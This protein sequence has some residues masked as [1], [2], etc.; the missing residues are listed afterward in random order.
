MN[1][2]KEMRQMRD[3]EFMSTFR[4]TLRLFI[5]RNSKNPRK[6]ALEF[7][8]NNSHPRYYVSRSR[9]YTV[10]CS[11]IRHGK[12]PVRQDLQAQMWEEIAQKVRLALDG[13]A[14][15]INKALNFVLDNC[16]ASR[17]FISYPYAERHA[18]VVA[19]ENRER[20]KRR[21]TMRNPVAPDWQ[22]EMHPR[23]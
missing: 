12:N 2:K 20:L 6:K 9:A 17:Y 16:R 5:D 4:K 18:Y 14:A 1:S 22:P 11:I 21:F 13:G 8:L 7:T 19:D 10:I 15:S 23:D 3:E